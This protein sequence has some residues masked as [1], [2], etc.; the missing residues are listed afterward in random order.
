M[1]GKILWNW[2]SW[3]IRSL[4]EFCEL[5]SKNTHK[6]QAQAGPAPLIKSTLTQAQAAQ[7]Q[8]VVQAAQQQAAQQQAAVAAQQQQLQ[9]TAATLV[10]RCPLSTSPLAN[11]LFISECLK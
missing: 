10:I 6:F 9:Y 8:A 2:E 11:W 5:K 7:Q 3:R 1:V 4:L